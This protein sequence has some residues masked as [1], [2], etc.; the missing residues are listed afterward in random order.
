VW[1]VAVSLPHLRAP[2]KTF[3]TNT[4]ELQGHG[5]LPGEAPRHVSHGD[6]VRCALGEF[7][8]SLE[9]PRNPNSAPKAT[10]DLFS[11]GVHRR[12]SMPPT[13]CSTRNRIGSDGCYAGT[14]P[15]LPEV[16][17]VRRTLDPLLTNARIVDVD[18]RRPDLRAPFPRR[19]RARL[20]GQTVRSL[21]RRGKY[22]LAALSSGETLVMHLGMSG[23]FRIESPDGS[24]AGEDEEA[25]EPGRHD[26]VVFHLSSG[27]TVTF[28]DP[29]RFGFMTLLTDAQLSRHP[30]LSRLGLEPL[31][32]AFDA[33]ALARAC[34][35]RKTSLKV[36]L[37][38]QRVVAG[39]GNIYACEALHVAGLSPI[40]RASTIAT[41]SGAPRETADR[42][43]AAI[44]RVLTRA[45]DGVATTRYRS[46]RFRVYDHEGERCPRTGC[47]GIIRRRTQ[48]GRSTFYCPICQL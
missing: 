44:K 12:Q 11:C 16:E 46:S 31:S 28:N 38:D 39:L 48:A 21:T 13:V 2:H 14:L 18:L 27:A 47:S 36:A 7:V 43:T 25:G 17:A 15:E 9:P 22:L 4:D 19:F 41:P 24:A 30:V 37:L 23:S 1:V 6:E 34:A 10:L 32:K 8:M 42:L 35:G 29:R 33:A 3:A 26:H 20:T 45:V 5:H 40:R